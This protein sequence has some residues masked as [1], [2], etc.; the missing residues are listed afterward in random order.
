MADGR[1]RVVEDMDLP[2]TAKRDWEMAETALAW[3]RENGLSP[4]PTTYAFAFDVVSGEKPDLR[5]QAREIADE[6]GAV[7]EEDIAR[8]NGDRLT[9][10]AADIARQVAGSLGETGR[11]LYEEMSRLAESLETH[12]VKTGG[13]EKKAAGAMAVFA[14][15]GVTTT[16]AA[17]AAVMQLA[18]MLQEATRA[19]LA[20]ARDVRVQRETV[21]QMR[22]D[23]AEQNQMIDDLN[24]RLAEAQQ[25]ASS[26]HLTSIP[27]RRG[28]DTSLARFFRSPKH[29]GKGALAVIDIDHFKSFNDRHGHNVGDQVLKLVAET[30]KKSVRGTDIVARYGGEEFSV[31]MPEGSQHSGYATAEKIRDAIRRKEFIKRSTNETIGKI[32]VSIGVAERKEGDT[33]ETLFERADARL[34]EAKRAGRDRVVSEGEFVPRPQKHA[35]EEPDAGIMRPGP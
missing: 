31:Y 24:E 20:Y 7:T 11:Q 25:E 15:P 5:R 26:D 1:G 21:A 6:R 23:L 22:G 16:P 13:F 27:N 14:Q 8:I 12:A 28:F 10:E 4:S 29:V 19:N 34:Y 9:E 3:L 30:I 2:E 35:G 33:A 18:A 32:T 17:K